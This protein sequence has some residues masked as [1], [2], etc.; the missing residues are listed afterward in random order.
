MFYK[1][2]E[3]QPI[4][5]SKIIVIHDSRIIHGTYKENLIKKG[6][7]YLSINMTSGTNYT[8]SETDVWCYIDDFIKLSNIVL[9]ELTN[10]EK[11]NK[12]NEQEHMD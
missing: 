7:Y 12:E 9:E 11:E 5:N 6:E 8:F 10:E 4:V 1:Y 3:L 2:K